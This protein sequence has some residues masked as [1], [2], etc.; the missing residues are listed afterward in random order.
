MNSPDNTDPGFRDDQQFSVVGEEEGIV[1]RF[2]ER[3]VA[4]GDLVP[5]EAIVEWLGD[6]D[7]Q[8]GVEAA[9]VTADPPTIFSTTEERIAYALA[10]AVIAGQRRMIQLAVEKLSERTGIES[11]PKDSD[12]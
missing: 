8:L 5:A 1:D 10:T 4:D 2:V 6:L 12:E 7:E 9:E 11:S 3:V